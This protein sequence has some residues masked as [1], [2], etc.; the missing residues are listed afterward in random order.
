MTLLSERRQV[1]E[2][3]GQAITAGARQEHACGAISLSERTLQRWQRDPSRGDQRPARV[4][5]PGNRLSGL[6]RQAL[7]AV[8]NSAEFGHLSPS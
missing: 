7:L 8:A 5:V 4:Q 1:I 6:E 2:L 3:V